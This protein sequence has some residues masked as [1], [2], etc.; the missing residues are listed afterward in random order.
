MQT[1][2]EIQT[3]ELSNIELSQLD[4]VNHN[5]PNICPED[6]I[7]TTSRDKGEKWPKCVYFIIAN[8]SMERFSYYGLRAILILFFTNGMILFYL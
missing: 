4:E 6:K 8:E 7:T 1:N 3:T 5:D 2:Q